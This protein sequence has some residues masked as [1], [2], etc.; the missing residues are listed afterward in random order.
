MRNTALIAIFITYPAIMLIE[1]KLLVG[2]LIAKLIF[3][4]LAA[5][6][7]GPLHA[8]AQQLFQANGRYQNISTSF[9]FG[10]CLSTLILAFTVKIYEHYN[11][12][13]LASLIL[14]ISS[15]ITWRSLSSKQQLQEKP[16]II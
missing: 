1:S 9:A 16:A 5:S 4:I 13:S 15:I 6:F 12:L 2:I 7:M 10:K 8:Y 3:A 11:S 14:V